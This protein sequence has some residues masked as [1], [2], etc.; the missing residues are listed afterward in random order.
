T[1]IVD[2]PR[3]AADGYHQLPDSPTVDA[4]SSEPD[5]GFDIDGDARTIG[6]ATDI[7]ADELKHGTT[8]ALACAPTTLSAGASATCT[9]TVD[10][11]APA[12]SSAPGGSIQ[13]ASDG[14][15]TFSGDAACALSQP[16]QGTAASC[17]V[18]YTP[19]QAEQG[20]RTI[21]A[22]YV[23]DFTHD[24]SERSATVT[25]RE[26]TKSVPDPTDPGAGGPGPTSPPNAPKP[27]NTRL[28]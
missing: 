12:G 28:K 18:T 8:L 2:P 1:N 9:A 3:L 11:D 20:E 10:D 15:G 14:N 4:D 5:G 6:V 27:P 23:G 13:F 24:G 7:G 21:T 22:S 26:P 19:A 25:V 16:A 17:E